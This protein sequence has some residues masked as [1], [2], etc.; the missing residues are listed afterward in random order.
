MKPGQQKLIADLFARGTKSATIDLLPDGTLN[1]SMP[2]YPPEYP[3]PAHGTLTRQ[4]NPSLYDDIR[5][6]Y[7]EARAKQS[8]IGDQR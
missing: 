6:L 4:Q 1:I 3:E 7:E 8:P 2:A 5:A